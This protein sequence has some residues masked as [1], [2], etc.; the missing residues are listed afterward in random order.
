[1]HIYTVTILIIVLVTASV[2]V[3]IVVLFCV[4]SK[5]NS[6]TVSRKLVKIAVILNIV[7]FSTDSFYSSVVGLA[8]IVYERMCILIILSRVKGETTQQR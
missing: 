3:L 2:F 6:V 4:L 7:V 5:H 8:L 1:M